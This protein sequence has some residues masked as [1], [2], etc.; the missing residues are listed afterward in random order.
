MKFIFYSH[1]DYSDIWDVLFGQCDKY[2]KNQSKVLFTDMAGKGNVPKDWDVVYYDE[3]LPYQER[4]TSCLAQLEDE[5]VVFSHEDMIPCDDIDFKTL[6]DFEELIRDDSVDFIKLLR[7]GYSDNHLQSKEHAYLVDCPPDMVF[8]IQPTICKKD[9]L[10]TMYSETPG[11]SIWEFEAQTL[12]TAAHH[13]FAGRMAYRSTDKKRGMYHYDSST[14]PYIATA[15]VKGKWYTSD[16]PEI[17]D[18]LKSYKIDITE[19][20]EA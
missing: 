12:H 14:Y 19:R 20:G 15:I 6:K 8:T 16:Y 11:S 17:K 18:L 1:S 3:K 10:M 7:G 13:E 5:I 9:R 2:L 4:V